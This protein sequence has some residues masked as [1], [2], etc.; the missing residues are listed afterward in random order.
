MVLGWLIVAATTGRALELQQVD[1][2][3]PPAKAMG[4]IDRAVFA[5]LD[6]L[7]LRPVLCSDEVFLRR[8]YLDVTGTLPTA[9]EAR[10][11]LEDTSPNKRP[12]LIDHLLA[13]EAHAS[14]FAMRWSD[15]LRIKAEFPINLWPNAAQAYHHWVREQVVENTPYDRFARQLL[16]SSGSNFR[17]G[18]VN[19]YRAIQN[20]TPEGITAAVALTFLGERTD[21]WPASRVQ[22]M[23][24]GFSQVGYKPTREWKEEI[25]YWD[26]FH[27]SAVGIN[28]ASETPEEAGSLTSTPVPALP[29]PLT[30]T[31]PDGT[32]VTIPAD[33][34]PRQ[35]F[36]DW[37]VRPENPA[38][39][40]AIANR[41]WSWLLGRGVIHEPDDIRDDNPPS[42]PELL[43]ALEQELRD[44]HFDLK[45]LYRTILNSSTYQ[46]AST[47]GADRPEAEAAIASDRVRRLEAEV[48]IDAINQITGTTELYTSPIPEPFTYIPRDVRAVAIADGSITS[49]FL[50][51]FGRSARVTGLESERLTN[52]VP[53]QWLLLLNSSL[54]QRKLEQGPG[55]RA[56]LALKGRNRVVEELYLTILSRRP[57]VEELQTCAA[58]ARSAGSAREPAIDLA[59]ALINSHEFL[60]RH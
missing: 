59:W 30:A 25:V 12:D 31:W 26:P 17:V 42:N 54:I 45:H 55:I 41:S 7:G 24:V 27:P 46:L 37:L 15:V 35:V 44:N 2:S 38:F 33:T 47:P 36:A 58:Y 16:T 51:L 60:Y 32:T 13:T 56:I 34:D 18:P 3:S 49:P 10:R 52:P 20:R 11:F 43:T 8:I 57:T 4:A 6:G 9:D 5:R 1:E 50:T 23:A 39:T 22:G 19:F 48:L 53:A 40:R 21:H 29:A 14:Y 28:A